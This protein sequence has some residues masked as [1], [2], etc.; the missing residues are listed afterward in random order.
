MQGGLSSGCP[1]AL[2][3]ESRRRDAIAVCRDFRPK[4]TLRKPFLQYAAGG[5]ERRPQFPNPGAPMANHAP[6]GA[7][8]RCIQRV[9]A[10]AAVCGT[11]VGRLE[12]QDAGGPS[13][14]S[15]HA[16]CSGSSM[17]AWLACAT[18]VLNGLRQNAEYYRANRSQALLLVGEWDAIYNRTR[19][20]LKDEPRYQTDEDLFR[21]FV[22]DEV[23]GAVQDVVEDKAWETVQ[24][25]ADGLARER[26]ETLD[27]LRKADSKAVKKALLA[28]IEAAFLASAKKY[29]RFAAGVTKVVRFLH[30]NAGRLVAVSLTPSWTETE[31]VNLENQNRVVQDELFR[32]LQ[33]TSPAPA[34]V[35]STEDLATSLLKNAVSG[36]RECPTIAPQKNSFI[37]H[38]RRNA[39]GGYRPPGMVS[40][41]ADLA[42]IG[43]ALQ[44]LA[45]LSANPTS[46]PIEGGN[47][48]AGASDRPCATRSQGA[49][50][51]PG[52]CNQ[53][54][55]QATPATTKAGQ[56]GRPTAAP[57]PGCLKPGD[58]VNP[59]SDMCKALRS[60]GE[61]R[62][63]P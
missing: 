42:A 56:K 5:F 20:T 30:A 40:T 13:R 29:P 27:P 36:C 1:D 19:L 7:A 18:G 61:R 26:L 16:V 63:P 43:A 9:L 33:P 15:V 55:P 41:G 35:T 37:G 48:R 12:A 31:L 17:S 6:S 21:D 39:L 60:A 46:V 25:Y 22:M 23:K 38:E 10:V 51:N 47:G 11:A 4:A 3:P 54:P 52:D 32:L 53:A 44:S 8:P 45:S 49:E 57:P 24:D 28:D 62:G 14:A 58:G 2:V 34:P 59:A 50:Y